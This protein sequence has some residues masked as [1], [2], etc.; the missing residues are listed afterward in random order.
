MSKILITPRSLTLKGDPALKILEEAGY[1]LVFTTPG[2]MP[3]EAELIRTVPG[4][5]GWLAGVEKITPRVLEA[6]D[7]LRVI[8]RNGTGVDSI[9]LRA[10]ADRNIPVMRAV[11]ANARGV[12]ELTVGFML[13]L[14]RAVSR[15]DRE[16]KAGRWTRSKGL[17]LAGRTLGLIGCGAVGR[18][19]AGIGL[20]F[21]MRV[22]AHDIQPDPNFRPS[23]RFE[24]AAIHEVFSRADFISLHLPAL[25]GNQ[26]VID[27][28]SLQTTQKGVYII[29]TSRAGLIDE[30]AVLEALNDGRVAGL[31]TDVFREEPPAPGP[32]LNHEK[33]I[34]TPH[35]GGY[36]EESITRATRDAVDNLLNVLRGEDSG[37]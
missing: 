17:E 36:T 26:A 8:S 28:A 15:S 35:I 3:D 11:G 31:A 33:V 12:A 4:C 29:N 18:I 6:A 10:A 37:R 24:Y 25:P 14:A 16:L 9:D 7:S 19:V 13:S 5:V 23:D 22:M 27:R 1:E 34:A 32:L 2:Q 21:G 30:E 20:G